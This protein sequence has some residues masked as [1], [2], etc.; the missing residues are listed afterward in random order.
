MK[1]SYDSSGGFWQWGTWSSG[2]TTRHTVV[3]HKE[4]WLSPLLCHIFLH[5][6]DEYMREELKANEPQPTQGSNAR[7]NPEYRQIENTIARLRRQRKQPQG[8]ARDRRITQLTD[9]ERQQRKTPYYAKDQPHPTNVGYA[10]D[11]DDFV[12]MVQG[13]N[14]EAQA[15]KDHIGKKLQAMGLRLSEEKTTLTHWRYRVT[16][17][18]YPL[19][20]TQ[21]RKGTSIRP[22]LSIPHEKGRKVK[23][24]LRQ[25]SEDHH[26]PEID[27]ISQM[28][29]MFR[30]WCHDYRDAKA[31]QATFNALSRHTWWCYAHDVARKYQSS[32]AA[33]LTRERQTG[34]R[35]TV[36]RNGRARLTFQRPVGKKTMILDLFPP[37]RGQIRSLPD[38]GNWTVDLKPLMPM[39]WQRGRRLATQIAA[40]ERAQGTGER[41]HE[42]PVAHVHHTVPLRG[43]TFRARIMSDS[44]QRYTAQA[45]CS[46]CHL[47]VHGGSYAPSRC[48]GQ[49]GEPDALKGACPVWEGLRQ[50]R[51]S[52]G[53]YGVSILPQM[54]RCVARKERRP[55]RRF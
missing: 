3:R 16:C 51:L 41:C 6:L 49:V 9:L 53:R 17:L 50:D 34:R 48:K 36:T 52:K 29:A 24:A 15:I 14:P 37:K 38:T 40:L 32:I 46:A 39:N 13:K 26:I 45:L 11:A 7:R 22:M 18:G 54:S 4:A 35:E 55:S 27:A 10:R 2:N 20:G 30:G 8:P 28:S 21:G 12:M 1:K 47:E 43:K 19:H 23:E 42:R 33:M 25:V 44:A 5:Q 31:P